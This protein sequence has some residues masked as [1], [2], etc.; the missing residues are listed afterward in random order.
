MGYSECVSIAL[1]R[2]TD[3]D[4]GWP[5]ER[6]GDCSQA[7]RALC[8]KLVRVARRIRHHVEHALDEVEWHVFMEQIAHRVHEDQTPGPPPLRDAQ[9]I[10][11]DREAEPGPACPRIAVYLV[12]RL[13]HVLETAGQR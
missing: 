5:F 8:Q 11:V 1:D 7:L 12:L 10:V 9:R 3:P 13:A 6:A 2:H 4:V